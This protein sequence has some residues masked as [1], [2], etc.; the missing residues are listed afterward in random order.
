MPRDFGQTDSG[1]FRGLRGR[2]RAWPVARRFLAVLVV[3]FLARET[4]N[5]FIFPPFTG[6]DEVA[7]YGYAELLA[8]QHRV[9]IIP[10][11]EEFRIAFTTHKEPLPGDYI[12]NELYPYCQFV[13]DWGSCDNP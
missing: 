11:L 5:V 10:N 4:L 12:P 1:T 3:L 9:P 6:H 7:H 2:F 8:T 13:L